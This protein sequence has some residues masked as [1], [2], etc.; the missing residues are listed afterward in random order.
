M[1]APV[2]NHTVKNNNKIH[3]IREWAERRGMRQ[4]DIVRGLGV[5]K[6]LVSKW[7][8]GA[9]PQAENILRLAELFALDE[10]SDLFRHPDD[11]WLAKFFRDRSQEELKRMIATLEAAFPKN[12]GVDR[13]QSNGRR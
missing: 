4:A 11:D 3:F 5:D 7:F 8:N 1:S 13:R 6:G 12:S 10:P 9:L 2:R